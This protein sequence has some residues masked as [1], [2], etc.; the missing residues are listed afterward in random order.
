MLQN[1]LKFFYKIGLNVPEMSQ[2][3]V[4]DIFIDSKKIILLFAG[5]D[6]T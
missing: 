6:F 2:H 1:E 4:P 3:V 5:T